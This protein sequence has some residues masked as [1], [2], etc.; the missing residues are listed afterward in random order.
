MDAT[1]IARTPNSFTLRF[2]VPYNDSMLGFEETLQHRLN[3][4]GVEVTAEGL[5]QFET[6]GSPITVG[7]AE[8]RARAR[9]RGITRPPMASPPSPGT[10]TRAPKA[11]RPTAHS[12]G[13][14]GRCGCCNSRHRSRPLG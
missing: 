9:S 13:T 2:E 7:P 5:R 3:E 11:P 12:T 6:D 4:A 1:I 14:P 8:T 10:S